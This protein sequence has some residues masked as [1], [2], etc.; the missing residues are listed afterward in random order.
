MATGW[1]CHHLLPLSLGRRPQIGDFLTSLAPHGLSLTDRTHNCL[2]LPSQ[3]Q[4]AVASGLALHRGPHPRY[5]DVL[6]ARIDAERQ[7]R[8]PAPVS[9][10]RLARL[11]RV[12]VRV[13][14]GRG[15]RLFLLNRRDPMRLFADYGALDAAIARYWPAE[16]VSG[17]G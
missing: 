4:L 5:T 16:P 1:Q 15:P 10:M 6:A 8:L 9:A 17:G 3:E 11:Q 12:M 13:L 7:R 2:L 14:A